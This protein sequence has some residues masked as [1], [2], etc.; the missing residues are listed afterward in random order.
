[1]ALFRNDSPGALTMEQAI[2]RHTAFLEKER[3][4]I[5]R[6]EKHRARKA[7]YAK[8]DAEAAAARG[9]PPPQAEDDFTFP[10]GHIMA[11]FN[12]YR[13]RMALAQEGRGGD[14]EIAH[15]ARQVRQ[16]ARLRAYWACGRDQTWFSSHRRA[17]SWLFKWHRFHAQGRASLSSSPQY[18][19]LR[20]S[21]RAG[22]NED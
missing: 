4:R 9:E 7:A 14:T 2:A 15:V 11:G 22:H 17:A 13:A 5:A 18:A 10:P 1:M 8:A 16:F 3:Q 20:L 19:A 12:P 21:E 6:R